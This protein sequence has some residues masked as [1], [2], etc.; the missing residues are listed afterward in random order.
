MPNPKSPT[1]RASTQEA[2][3]VEE[4]RD[5]LV[6][7]KDGS[8]VLILQVGA[9]NFDLLSEKEQSAIILAYGGLLN[10]LNFPVQ[11]FVRSQKKDIT[12]Y[13]KL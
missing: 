8:A 11:I 7:L 3:P 13:T 4:I 10:S 12:A 2:L 1:I 5:D 6:I 9:I